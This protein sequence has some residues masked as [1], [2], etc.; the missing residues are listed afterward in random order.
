LT[1]AE[2]LEQSAFIID[3]VDDLVAKVDATSV[4]N[5]AGLRVY[6]EHLDSITFEAAG[7]N[8]F[9]GGYEGSSRLAMADG[10][11]LM[12]APIGFATHTIE[13]GGGASAFG[14][15]TLVTATVTSVPEPAYL[16]LLAAGLMGPRYA[17]RRMG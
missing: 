10:Y 1:Q 11:Y 13:Y 8:P 12:L 7:D 9:A 16:A 6:L 4:A 5:L 17:P 3:K 14:L 2:L 15:S